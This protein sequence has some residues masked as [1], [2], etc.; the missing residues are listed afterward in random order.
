MREDKIISN[1][2]HLK[3][4]DFTL[5]RTNFAY[6]M[7]NYGPPPKELLQSNVGDSKLLESLGGECCIM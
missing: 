5:K 1:M 6:Q 2:S 4:V 3:F 7:Q